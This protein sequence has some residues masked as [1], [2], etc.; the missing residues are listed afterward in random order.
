MDNYIVLYREAED[1]HPANPPLLFHCQ[2]DDGDHAEEQ[3]LAANPGCTV[4]WTYRGNDWHGAFDDYYEE[5]T[6]G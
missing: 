6:N 5:Q 3:C 4:A 2:A 1:A